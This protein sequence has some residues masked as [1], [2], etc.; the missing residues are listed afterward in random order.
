MRKLPAE[1]PAVAGGGGAGVGGRPQY[2]G[3]RWVGWAR[4]TQKRRNR[5]N[6][7]KPVNKNTKQHFLWFT[8]RFSSDIVRNEVNG[9]VIKVG[10]SEGRGFNMERI[11][12]S[13]PSVNWH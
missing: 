13:L 3:D 12:V 7:V 5:Y 9:W 8:V 10:G 11:Q 1:V 6:D 4:E 2:A